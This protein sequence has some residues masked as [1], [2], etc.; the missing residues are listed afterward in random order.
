[1][2]VLWANLK[3]PELR[4]AADRDAIVV[5]PV[6]AT[7]QHGPH[8]PVQVDT[9]LCTEIC[10]RAAEIVSRRDEAI[11]VAPC[12]WAGLSE[13][14]L[15]FGGTFTLDI[16]TFLGL[17]RCLVSSLVRQHFRRI[18]FVN[19]HGGNIAALEVAAGQLALEFD[20]PILAMTYWHLAQDAFG[21]ILERQQTVRH[22]CEAETSMMMRLVPNLVDTTLLP[23]ANERSKR[24]PQDLVGASVFRWFPLSERTDTGVIGDPALATA[25]KGE[26]LLAAAAEALSRALLN[27]Q[28]WAAPE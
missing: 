20:V 21:G 23:L 14:H 16:K 2:S 19:G 8:L 17:L 11:L 4:A 1:M 7:E 6:A 26:R 18:A 3:A 5:L 9:I 28:A 22:A 24:D 13:H 12:V 15:S 27:R 25:E 10:H